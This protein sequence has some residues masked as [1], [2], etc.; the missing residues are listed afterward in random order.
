MPIPNEFY[1]RL[2]TQLKEIQSQGLYKNERPI[3]SQ[4]DAR[5]EVGS[6]DR[7]LNFCANN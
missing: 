1:N 7:V 3:T 5:I 4:Q 2:T 6:A